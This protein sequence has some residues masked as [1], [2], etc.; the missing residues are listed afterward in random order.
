MTHCCQL[1]APVCQAVGAAWFQ[2]V[3]AGGT[4]MESAEALVNSGNWSS[5]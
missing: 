1:V 4:A 2:L 5:W 3:A